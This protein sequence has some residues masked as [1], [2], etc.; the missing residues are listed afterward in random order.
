M[1]LASQS[2]CHSVSLR[3]SLGTL[4]SAGTLLPVTHLPACP[5][6]SLAPF[7]P[8][9][10]SSIF[11]LKHSPITSLPWFQLHLWP[12][13]PFPLCPD[14]SLSLAL[15]VRPSCSPETPCPLLLRTSAPAETTLALASHTCPHLILCLPLKPSQGLS[16][17]RTAARLG[18]LRRQELS[19]GAPGAGVCSLLIEGCRSLGFWV[20][21]GVPGYLHI[22]V[23]L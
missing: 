10:P 17:G 14:R 3:S 16:L 22:P 11:F 2:A 4:L 12:L 6:H 13:T 7:P 21:E 9:Q 19:L 15:L 18:T 20:G 23:L 8:F 5:T 1:S